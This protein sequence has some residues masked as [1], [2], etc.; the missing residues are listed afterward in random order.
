MELN[1]KKRAY[2]THRDSKILNHQYTLRLLGV[3]EVLDRY[4]I[5]KIR[6]ERVRRSP[7]KLTQWQ[8]L[9]ACATL[10]QKRYWIKRFSILNRA[11][12][13]AEIKI[14]R[15]RTRITKATLT[16]IGE[17]ALRVRMLNVKR[18]DLKSKLNKMT[19]TDSN[20]QKS[21]YG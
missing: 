7:Q 4:T 9:I 18:N 12:W 3:G 19:R 1:K 17:L 13:D 16:R 14:H 20:L 11:I 5:L 10:P 21:L 15:N 6:N 2:E 8:K